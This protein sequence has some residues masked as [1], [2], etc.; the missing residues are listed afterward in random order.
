[1]NQLKKFFLPITI[2]LSILIISACSSES[3]NEDAQGTTIVNKQD[4]QP[5]EEASNEASEK[6]DE[7]EPSDN[8]ENSALTGLK[9]SKKVEKTFN[10]ND[11]F[12]LTETIVDMNETYVQRVLTLG[13]MVTLQVL[14][15]NKEQMQVVYEESNP[16]EPDKSILDNFTPNKEEQPLVD[17][18][19][20]GEGDSP[21]WEIISDNKTV[22]VPYATYNNVFEVRSTVKEGNGSSIHTI[23]YA[24]GIGMIKEIFEETGD[25]GYIA[26]SVLEKVKEQ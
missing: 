9:P 22:E 4:N 12:T 19:K 15:W 3:E 20:R 23:Y 14:K 6:Q 8:E 21:V 5:N 24:P 2:I 7:N 26:E 25:D 13:D 11:E 10:Q 17:L 1:M 18:S 16:S